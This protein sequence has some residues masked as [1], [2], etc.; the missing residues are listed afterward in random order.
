ML[1]HVPADTPYVM[2]S[3]KPMPAEYLQWIRQRL[4]PVYGRAMDAYIA[5]T[6][7]RDP[8]VTDFFDQLGKLD[9]ETI[10][11]DTKARG[12]VY[13]IDQYPVVRVDLASGAKL[14]AYMQQI[15]TRHHSVL[16]PPTERGGYKTWT[17]DVGS[18][19]WALLIGIGDKEAVA[20]AAPRAKLDASTPLILGETLPTKA[21]HTADLKAVAARD[22]YTGQALGYLDVARVVGM[23]TDSSG[24]APA[25]KDAILALAKRTPRITV[26]Y[27]DFL[28][29]RMSFGVVVE[30]APDVL[31]EARETSGSVAGLARM[32]H[33]K[34]MMGVAV[35]ANIGKGRAFLDHVARALHSVAASCPDSGLD[36]AASSLHDTATLPLPPMVAN[37]H[38]GVASIRSMV[39][40]GGKPSQID[41]YVT[42]Q[43]DH[44]DDLLR[45]IATKLPGLE[46][47]ADGKAHALPSTIPFPGHDAATKDA[48]ALAF[49]SDSAHV[50]ADVLHDKA[51]PAPLVVMAFDYPKLGAMVLPS[52]PADQQALM[53]GIFNA[54]G[55][56]TM[57]ML[58]DDRGLVFWGDLELR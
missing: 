21:L 51:T 26:G 43:I 1:A 40:S 12:V 28:K 37:V 8:D 22:G 13:G 14:L 53:S 25:C 46:L 27:D 34:P 30:L 15:A 58:I 9:F 32:I 4:G 10:G 36:G 56:A 52:M 45:M 20:A 48:V 7:S 47:D 44:A 16:P 29:T 17:T 2:A 54:F 31:T 23:L 11:I 50:A 57:Q 3:F 42:A 6:G 39:M 35:A 33:D 55:L 24:A 38:G 41:G 49:G 19:G 5:K 18:T